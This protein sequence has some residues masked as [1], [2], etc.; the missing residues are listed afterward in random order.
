MTQA[1]DLGGIANQLAA[2]Y[3]ARVNVNLQALASQHYGASEP[4][5][6][7]P[8]MIW[9]CSGDGYIKVRNPTNTA[10][11]NIGTIGPPMKWTNVDV[12]STGWSTGDVKATYKWWADDGWVLLND[13]SIG[14]ANSGAVTRFNSD[15]WPLF[16]LLWYGTSDD[17]CSL[18]AAYTWTRTGRGASPEADFAA[19]RHILLPKVLGRVLASAG[20][21][22]GLSAFGLATWHG[23][24]YVTLGTEHM[25]WHGHPFSATVPPHTHPLGSPL[26]AYV[27]GK[28][29]SSGPWT[30]ADQSSGITNTGS[31]GGATISGSTGGAGGGQPHW[32]IQPT[33][34]CNYM[35]KL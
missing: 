25:P 17:W 16:N 30:L 11:A 29:S 19:H 9:F 3:R 14:D 24:E 23:Q 26:P 7:Y 21:G 32:N 27:A 22:A 1:S 10:W 8:N 28:S 31:G 33:T 18:Y 34:Y 15:T 13:G 20:T 4:P 2:F 5:V 6:M 12:P 35:I